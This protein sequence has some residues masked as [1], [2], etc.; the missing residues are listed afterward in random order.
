M[1]YIF[2]GTPQFAAIILLKLI[3]AGMPP[4]LVV[5]NPDKPA[6]RK[7]ELTSPA[8]KERIKEK[9]LRI[10]VIQP[11]RLTPDLFSD[12]E[13]DFFVVAAYGKIIPKSILEIPRLGTINV[14]PSLLPKYRGPTPIQTAILNGDAV[15]G[16]S[17]ILLDREVDHGPILAER[18]HTM[19]YDDDYDT[20]APKLAELG[21][22]MLIEIL[23]KYIA[24]KITPVPQD[25]AKATFTKKFTTADAEISCEDLRAALEGNAKQAEHIHRMARALNPEPGTWVQADNNP[26]AGLPKNKRVKILEVFVKGDTLKLARIQAEGKQPRDL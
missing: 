16:V 19:T 25:H 6:G 26:P 21:A 7:Q 2:F 22:E 9:G 3:Q 12:E 17:L 4:A 18:E 20:L 10:K 8:V 23:P 24:G 1:K 5:T 15:T 11:E 14:H 13:W